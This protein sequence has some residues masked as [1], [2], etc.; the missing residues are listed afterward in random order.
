MGASAWVSRIAYQPD[1]AAALQAARWEA[2]RGGHYYHSPDEL[3]EARTMTEDEFVA[4]MVEEYG[5]NADGAET[6]LAWR[7]A[8]T[9]PDSPDALAVSQ[10]YSG[11]HSVIDMTRVGDTPDMFTV[12]P[13]SGEVLDDLFATRTPSTDAV[14]TAAADGRL[15]LYGRWHGTYVVGYR[16]GEP[17][18]IFFVGHSGD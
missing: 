13:P 18:A 5:P 8:R 4:W 2:F 15:D 9:G 14:A 11:T 10:P 7:A 1:I 16:G 3:P 17:E 6:R 12:A